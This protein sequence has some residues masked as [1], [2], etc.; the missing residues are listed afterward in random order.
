MKKAYANMAAQ[1][2]AAN[3]TRPVSLFPLPWRRKYANCQTSKK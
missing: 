1:I 3:A 2:D